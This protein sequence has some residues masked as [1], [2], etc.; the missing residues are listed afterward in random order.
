MFCRQL[1]LS[2]LCPEP[3]V[4]SVVCISIQIFGPGMQ[5]PRESDP[6]PPILSPPSHCW[7]MRPLRIP[8]V[9]SWT[10]VS[11]FYN[12]QGPSFLFTLKNIDWFLETGLESHVVF[13]MNTNS[14]FCSSRISW[15]S[16]HRGQGGREIQITKGQEV[17]QAT[18]KTSRSTI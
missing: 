7:Q 3:L 4:A 17:I 15:R 8:L 1:F 6:T 10:I 5:D 13:P 18:N 16:G 11:D 12:S 9:R 2:F 14:T